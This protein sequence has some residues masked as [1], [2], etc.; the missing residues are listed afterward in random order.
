MLLVITAIEPL[1][2]RRGRQN[3]IVNLTVPT[4]RKKTG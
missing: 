3:L 2:N 4:K 1:R